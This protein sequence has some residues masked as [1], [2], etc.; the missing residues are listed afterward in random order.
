ML[1]DS[2]CLDR[3]FQALADPARRGMLARLSRGPAS[4]SASS[5]QPLPISLPAVLQHLQAL[6]ASGLIRTEKKGRVRTCRLEP[7]RCPPP[8]PGSPSSA[9]T[10]KR[11]LDRFE[12]HLADIKPEGDMTVTADDRPRARAPAR[13]PAR[14][15]L[16]GLDRPRAYQAMVGAPALSDA[17]VRDRPAPWRQLP[18]PDDRARRFPRGRHRLHPRGRRGRADRLDQ[19]AGAGYRPNE[20]PGRGLRRLPVHRDPSP[21]RTPATARPATPRGRSH[22][23]EDDAKTHAEM[24]FH[25]GWGTCA[26][27]LGEVARGL[28][29][30]SVTPKKMRRSEG[31]GASLFASLK[32]ALSYRDS[33][34]GCTRNCCGPDPCL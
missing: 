22:R 11:R 6:E 9:R 26:D 27:Q 34:T 33:R 7:R 29:H 5:P 31:P 24:G 25:D 16:E 1:N 32:L 30:P 15:R 12:D 19:R 3:A 2:T 17:R 10:G 8:K 28:E 4:V 13:R 14:P 18:D 20:L 21:S 23:N